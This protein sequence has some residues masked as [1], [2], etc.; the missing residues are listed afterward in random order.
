M[1]LST[2][3]LGVMMGASAVGGIANKVGNLVDVYNAPDQLRSVGSIDLAKLTNADLSFIEKYKIEDY[4]KVAE[5]YE[6]T[7]YRVDI[8]CDS[9]Y[10]TPF[11]DFI[12]NRALLTRHYFNPIQFSDT[13]LECSLNVSSSLL[14]DFNARLK[15]GIRL[16]NVGKADVNMGDFAYDN[17]EEDYI[18]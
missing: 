18:Q 13:G 2:T 16:W 1:G 7:G 12:E 6:R 4:E 14:A 3:A 15:N 11:I 17:V 10:R 9:D 5:T 8:V